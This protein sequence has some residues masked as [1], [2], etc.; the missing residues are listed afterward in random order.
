MIERKIIKT[1][2]ALP[3]DIKEEKIIFRQV[4]EHINRTVA[5]SLGYQLETKYWEDIH[6][7]MGRP[8]EIINRKEIDKRILEKQG[9]S[10]RRYP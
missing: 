7:S 6:P 8:Q 3:D 10:S 5:H 1:F 2:L 9:L 4:I